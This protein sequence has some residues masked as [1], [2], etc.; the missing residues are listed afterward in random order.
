MLYRNYANDNNGENLYLKIGRT[1]RAGDVNNFIETAKLI[2][3]G[4]SY[5][6]GSQ[7]NE[8]NFHIFIYYFF[9]V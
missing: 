6:V 2:F 3:A 8:A 5:N 4:I 7:L 9:Y 1:L